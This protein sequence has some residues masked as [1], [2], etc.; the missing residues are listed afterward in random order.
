MQILNFNLPEY[1]TDKGII[2]E[3]YVFNALENNKNLLT[4]NYFYRTQSKTE[5]DFISI[6]EEVANLIEVKSYDYKKNIRAFIEFEKKYENSFKKIDKT[7]INKSNLDIKN[8][9]KYLPA[10]LL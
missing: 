9:I 8:N 1:R 6:T 7:I 5:I 3:N 10:Y 2:Y 4:K